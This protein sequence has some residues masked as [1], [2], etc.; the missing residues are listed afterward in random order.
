MAVC[1]LG[2][3]CVRLTSAIVFYVSAKVCEVHLKEMNSKR[4]DMHIDPVLL[5]PSVIICS[6]SF[7]WACLK[8]IKFPGRIQCLGQE[9][10]ETLSR[11]RV[12]LWAGNTSGFYNSL[13]ELLVPLG[14]LPCWRC[15]L[16][17]LPVKVA[18]GP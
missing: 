4:Q 18:R 3:V 11:G 1:K 17:D 10:E 2:S 7:D 13:L 5:S 16:L 6:Q 8:K 9:G 15:P 12:G 14:C